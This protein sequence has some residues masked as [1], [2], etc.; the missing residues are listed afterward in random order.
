MYAAAKSQRLLFLPL[1]QRETTTGL[2]QNTHFRQIY[3]IHWSPLRG[4]GRNKHIFTLP[5]I[6]GIRMHMK[7]ER[8]TRFILLCISIRDESV[9][10][11]FKKERGRQRIHSESSLCGDSLPLLQGENETLECVLAWQ[12]RDERASDSG[13]WDL[14]LL[15]LILS[16]SSAGCPRTA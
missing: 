11:E 4:K 1:R 6:R 12:S 8:I 9:K 16:P 15:R 7:L 2:I 3:S 14:L 5:H 10:A 13:R